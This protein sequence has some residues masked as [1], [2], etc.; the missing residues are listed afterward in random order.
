MIA[1]LPLILGSQLLIQSV[2]VDMQNVPNEALHI[3]LE[4]LEKLQKTFD[5]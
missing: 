1:V 5:K 3:D 2:L 4:S